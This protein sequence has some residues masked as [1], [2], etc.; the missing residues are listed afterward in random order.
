M[1]INKSNALKAVGF[2]GVH[3]QSET[4][5]ED[6]IASCIIGKVCD[7]DVHMRPAS[8]TYLCWF[9]VEPSSENYTSMPIPDSFAN[10]FQSLESNSEIIYFEI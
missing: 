1:Q 8:Q 5:I 9:G 7:V 4:S 10:G 2:R 3:F 6:K